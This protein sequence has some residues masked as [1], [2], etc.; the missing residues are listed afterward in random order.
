MVIKKDEI[1]K[2]VIEKGGLPTQDDVDTWEQS[3]QEFKTKTKKH[4]QK[5]SGVPTKQGKLSFMPTDM[6]RTSPFFPIAKQDM[7][8]RGLVGIKWETSWSRGRMSGIKL[9]IY[10]ETVFY[11]LL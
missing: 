10:D 11:A 8:N 3:M 1:L 7:K 5:Y 4:I 6:T 9:S 2:R